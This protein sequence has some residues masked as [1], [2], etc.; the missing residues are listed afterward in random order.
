R[1]TKNAKV[2][3]Y[4]ASKPQTNGKHVLLCQAKE[5]FP[6]LVKFTWQAEDHGGQK[7]D[8]KAE[9]LEQR[10]EVPDVKI[11]SMLI[12]DKSQLKSNKFTCF[13][14]HIGNNKH[15]VVI[16]AFQQDEE[17]PDPVPV[18]TCPTPK[19][20]AQVIKEEEEEEKPIY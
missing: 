19:V 14:D 1:T 12:V 11:T 5:M 20:K 9:V 10:D 4:P 16:P 8:L 7:V 17:T 2:S 13:V 3:G 6:D 18:N 15:T